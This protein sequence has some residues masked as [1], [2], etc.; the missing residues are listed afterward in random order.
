MSSAEKQGGDERQVDEVDH[1]P[2]GAHSG[3]AERNEPAAPA[4]AASRDPRDRARQ[5]AP[6][7]AAAQGPDNAKPQVELDE[8]G[9]PVRK[10]DSRAGSKS[11]LFRKNPEAS[12]KAKSKES[13]E[14]P[15]RNDSASPSPSVQDKEGTQSAGAVDKAE[16]S[17]NTGSRSTSDNND[18]ALVVPDA[19][20]TSENADSQD[21]QGSHTRKVSAGVSA[22]SHQRLADPTADD[23][24][25]SSNDDVGEWK[26]MPALGELDHYDD[27]GRLVAKG[28]VPEDDE[29][30]Y[31][32]LGGAGKG[33]T[34]IRLDDDDSASA[35]SMDEK[36]SYLF[37]EGHGTSAGIDDN[38]RDPLSQLQ[39][40][41]ELL[42]EGQRIAYV[43][44]VR[45]VIHKMT[46]DLENIPSTKSS[47][48]E[49]RNAVDD[50]KKWGQAVMIRLFGHMD[51]D[52]AEQVMIEQLSEHGV[53]PADLVPPLMRNTRVK[54][55]MAKTDNPSSPSSDSV[56]SPS[57]SSDENNRSPSGEDSR[58]PSG[59]QQQASCSPGNER[60]E[61]DV[62]E[63]QS[64]SQL[65]TS[66]NIELDLRWTV[67]CD[68]FLV[69]ISD[70]TYDARSRTLLEQ[71]GSALDISWLQIC[72]FEKRVIDALE[73]EQEASK[74][75]WDEAEN[76]EARRKQALKSKYMIMGLATV[77]GGLI[78]GLSAGLLAPV[79]GAGLAAGL[80]T[81]GISG[82]GAFFGGAGGTAL[83]ASG[84][85]LT[86][87][88]TGLR[89][90][91]RRTGAVKTFEYRPLHNNKRVNLIVTISGW[92][93]GKVDDVRLPFSTVDPIMGDLYSVYWEP[94]MLQSMGQTI[95]ILATEV[96]WLLPLK[97]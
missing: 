53:Q 56:E 88:I 27:Y 92:M 10:K 52:A 97:A 80:T 84:A 60:T 75:T 47:K 46:T 29:A 78:I 28:S 22:W 76:M 38:V 16:E 12:S 39:A 30:V 69:L 93:T 77:S 72:R 33:Y 81:I 35:A 58:P 67:L 82:T 32:G 26:A 64:P 14:P 43:G 45:L 23:D 48:K 63:V 44:V 61:D 79:I 59:A 65:P 89:A 83:I 71:V 51:I 2:P 36:T 96:G 66:E 25:A 91:N 31:S 37:K 40:T 8:F 70:S 7:E 9:L 87:G 3:T 55:P 85:T 73:M 57:R 74:E 19:S 15:K 41:K 42:T 5:P 49:L 95:N 6:K 54:N 86:G 24:E 20:T 50:M 90:S 94:E 21:V 17:A 62:P 34:R 18:N 11:R 13:S 1:P 68:L 4:A